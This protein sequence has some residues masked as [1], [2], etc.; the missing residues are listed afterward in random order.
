MSVKLIKDKSHIHP[1]LTV[2]ALGTFRRTLGIDVYN[3]IYFPCAQMVVKLFDREF[4][5]VMSEEEKRVY[6]LKLE[7]YRDV[8]SYQMHKIFVRYEER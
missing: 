2:G 8:L 3:S 4:E 6:N 1:S 5:F 7:K